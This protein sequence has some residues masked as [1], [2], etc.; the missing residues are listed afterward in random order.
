MNDLQN[1][2]IAFLLSSCIRFSH[3]FYKHTIKKYEKD[4][5]VATLHNFDLCVKF[6]KFK[7]GDTSDFSV[8]NTDFYFYD[9]KSNET[10]NIFSEWLQVFNNKH[11]S[12]SE[13]KDIWN[14]LSNKNIIL[15]AYQFIPI[16]T[17]AA[18]IKMYKNT[19]K[20]LFIPVIIDYGVDGSNIFHQTALII[21]FSGKILYYEP[22][23]RYIK[24]DKSYS[25]AMIDLFS[26]Y[27]SFV[28]DKTT[29]DTYHNYIYSPKLNEY[30]IQYYILNT[31]NEEFE[32]FEKKYNI[33][34]DKISDIA[35]KYKI[36]DTFINNLLLDIKNNLITDLKNNNDQTLISVYILASLSNFNI[37]SPVS[38]NPEFLTHFKEIYND[39]LC[40]YYKY[41]SQTC[42]TITIYEMDLF[43]NIAM[44]YYS[45]TDNKIYKE[46]SD[47]SDLEKRQ[48]NEIRKI[49]TNFKLSDSPNKMLLG[50]INGLIENFELVYRKET[51]SNVNI[52]T[53]MENRRPNSNTCKMFR[54]D[55]E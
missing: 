2:K 3:K 8:K 48:K 10:K 42:V 27:E 22:Y 20:Y 54:Y 38:N 17:I 33:L 12:N 52:K 43:F 46:E 24:F 15:T 30:G 55:I 25:K 11:L 51:P 26:I 40:L 44:E 28:G 18:L 16:L 53:I 45:N 19:Y 4:K 49:Y 7:E 6:N 31:N 14:K 39:A 47:K 21:D 50:N 41:N 37:D 34:V 23:G 1:S 36:T 29:T 5:I 35:L 9:I 13:I 32:A